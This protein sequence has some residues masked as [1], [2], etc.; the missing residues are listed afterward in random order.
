MDLRE[1]V[2]R[3]P[4]ALTVFIA[5]ICISIYCLNFEHRFVNRLA[6][7]RLG[8]VRALGEWLFRVL[9]RSLDRWALHP[10]LMVREKEYFRLLTHGLVHLNYIHL[11]VNMLVF[12]FFVF[13]LEAVLGHIDFLL[14]YFGSM[15]AGG[16][17]STIRNRDNESYVSVGA[18]GALSG[19]L[20]GFILLRPTAMLWI[21]FIIPMPAW[22]FALLFAFGSYYAARGKLSI[23]IIINKIGELGYKYNTAWMIRLSSRLQTQYAGG[24]GMKVD[25]EGH[26]WG[27]LSGLVITILL[28]PGIVPFFFRQVFG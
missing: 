22:L 17:I 15:I 27:A 26:L 19:A 11:G 2:I 9:P 5:T 1:I 7:H 23:P 14:I 18:S 13:F 8:P 20:F 25:H 21:F 10:Y 4:V 6:S 3:A 16:Y 12:Y 24:S 28:H